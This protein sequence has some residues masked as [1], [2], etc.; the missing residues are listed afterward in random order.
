V[1][2][3]CKPFVKR[4]RAGGFAGWFF[5]PTWPS[6]ILFTILLGAIGLLTLFAPTLLKHSTFSWNDDDAVVIFALF[7]GLIFPAVWQIFLFRG[8]GQRFAHYLL[9]LVGSLVILAVLSALSSSMNNGTFLWFFAWNPLAF[10]AM[11]NEHPASDSA[12][13]AGVLL[14]DAALLMLLLV[15]ALMQMRKSAPVIEETKAALESAA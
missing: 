13:L 15:H 6:G 9:L 11:L 12:L 4:G 3:V 5:Y 14:V 1:Q 7:G 10:I 2:T 8:D